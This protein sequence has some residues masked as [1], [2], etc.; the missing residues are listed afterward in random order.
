[1]AGKKRN[2]LKSKDLRGFKYFK[3]LSGM[4]AALHEAGCERDRAH[5]R[6]LHMDQYMTLLLMFMFNPMCSSLRALAGRRRFS[7]S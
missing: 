6:T 2:K 3:I 4:L 7:E 5:N 1:M